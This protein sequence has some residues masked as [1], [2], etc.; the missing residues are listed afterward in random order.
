MNTKGFIPLAY[1]LIV[2]GSIIISGLLIAYKPSVYC[3]ISKVEPV[4]IVI[5]PVQVVQK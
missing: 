4:E 3:S 5:P 1:V 2:S